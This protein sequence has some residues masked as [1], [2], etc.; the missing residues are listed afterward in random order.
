[1]QV[2]IGDKIVET[3]EFQIVEGKA[4]PVIKATSEEIRYPDGRVDCIVHVPCLTIKGKEHLG[5]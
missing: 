3:D 1:M 2:R 4:V 5:K